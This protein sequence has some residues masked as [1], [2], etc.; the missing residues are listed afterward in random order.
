VVIFRNVFG[1]PEKKK[2]QPFQADRH[3]E[4]LKKLSSKKKT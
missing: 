3:V 1:M 2:V 4:D